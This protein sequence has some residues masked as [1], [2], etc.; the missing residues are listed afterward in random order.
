MWKTKELKKR[1]GVCQERNI[2][3]VLEA[4][5]SRL[6]FQHTREKGRGGVSRELSKR[7]VLVRTYRHPRRERLVVVELRT[8]QRLEL[9]G[10]GVEG[11]RAVGGLE[12]VAH[13]LLRHPPHQPPVEE[14]ARVLPLQ[15]RPDHALRL[16]APG[17]VVQVGELVRH[18]WVVESQICTPS[19]VS[20]QQILVG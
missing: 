20:R 16:H 10:D 3:S 9:G 19:A 17:A 13:A 15:G 6:S 12:V 11:Q 7:S 14:A 1:Y 2:T 18:L 8:R 4:E 5:D